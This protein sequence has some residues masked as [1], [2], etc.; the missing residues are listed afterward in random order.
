MLARSPFDMGEPQAG[1]PVDHAMVDV[2]MG[3]SLIHVNDRFVRFKL[4]RGGDG[5]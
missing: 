5:R 1:G 3:F 2:V 4:Y